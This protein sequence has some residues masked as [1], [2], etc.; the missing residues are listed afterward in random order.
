MASR[1]AQEVESTTG[2]R[3]RNTPPRAWA[4]NHTLQEG[5]A[6]ESA[7]TATTTPAASTAFRAALD[8]VGAALPEVA[9]SIRQELADQRSHLKLIASENFASP[10]VLLAMGNWLSDKYAEGSPGHRF[11]AGCD[12]VDA[13][14]SRAVELAKS[15]FGATHAYVQPHSGI[16]AN[17][18]AFWA[19]LTQRVE[20][21]E[22]ER[23]NAKDVRDLSAEDWEALRRK[24]GSQKMM[25][26]ALDAGGHLTHGFRPNVSGK[27]FE[28]TSYTV[29]PADEPPRLRRGAEARPR[30]APAAPDRAATAPIRARSTSASS[31]RSPTRSARR[32]WSTWRTSPASS[33][34]RSSPA[35]STPSA[36]PTS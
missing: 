2:K 8:V 31:A 25:G 13:I 6:H 35:T 11:Y 3:H 12:N 24:L 16:D 17:L 15:L 34:A 23:L 30:G 14:E 20:A 22:L 36:T 18:V 5:G 1:L 9:D 28:Y 21:P 19:V 29:D 27:L 33:P 10:A 4:P 32:S 7:D 26:M